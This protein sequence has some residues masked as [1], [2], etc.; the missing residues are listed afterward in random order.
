MALR[1][2]SARIIVHFSLSFK[3]KFRIHLPLYFARSLFIYRC[4]VNAI[5]ER[6]LCYRN[7]CLVSS[8][9][10]RRIFTFSPHIE[11]FF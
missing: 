7:V 11:F 2:T 10:L 5:I 9:R 3:N 8:F 1:E 6:C 4:G